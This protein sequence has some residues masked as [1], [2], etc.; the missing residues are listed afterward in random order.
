MELFCIRPLVVFSLSEM[1][2]RW[3]VKYNSIFN[4]FLRA[5]KC[6]GVGYDKIR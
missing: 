6:K 2:G 3:N 5:L 4:C 1:D